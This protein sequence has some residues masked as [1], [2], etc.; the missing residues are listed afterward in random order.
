MSLQEP[1]AQSTN[2][3]TRSLRERH[4]RWWHRRW[5][6][7][8]PTNEVVGMTPLPGAQPSRLERLRL[9]ANRP[10]VHVRTEALIQGGITVQSGAMTLAD[11]VAPESVDRSARDWIRVGDSFLQT[12]QIVSFPPTLALGWLHDPALGLDLPGITVHQCIMPVPDGMAR[13]ILNRSESAAMTTIA[14]DEV[15][16]SSADVEAEQGGR[17]AGDLRRDLAAGRD[18]M[19]QLAITITVSAPS[20][21][22]LRERVDVLR[23]AGAQFGIGL[24]PLRG[25]QWEGYACSLPLAQIPDLA[26]ADVSGKAAAMGLP[27]SSTGIEARGGRP[28]IWGRHPATDAPIIVDRWQQKNPHAVVVAESGS[29]KT[30]AL[31]GQI[32]QDVLLGEDAVL[33]LDPK[34]QEY[35][36]VVQGLGGVYVSMSGRSG[37]HINPL[38]LPRLTPERQRNVATLEED[39]LGQ[40]ITF[41][42]ALLVQEFRAMGTAVTGFGSSTI[43]HAIKQA[44]RERGITSDPATFTEAMPILS[45]VERCFA[46]LVQ[47]EDRDPELLAILRA[48]PH[49]TTGTLGDLFNHP[50]NI[51]VDTPLL[52]LDL[53]ALLQSKDE[54]LERIVPVV[55][56]DFFVTIAINRPTGRRSH[57]ILDEAHALLQSD[58]GS[59]TLQVVYRI[60]R[61]LGFMATV[62]TQSLNDL[63]DTAYARVLLE[64][65]ETKLV[66]GLNKDSDAVRRAADVLHLNE[67]EEAWLAH[68][69]YVPGEGSTALLLIG[70]Q[71]SPLKIPPWPQTLHRMIVHGATT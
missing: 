25:L 37:F 61:S 55:V 44:Y 16:G 58:A 4:A 43:E 70:G 7:D 51:P 9:A 2:G 10:I 19:M 42:K 50:S 12:L 20:L 45:D 59:K 33:I 27:I 35:R 57:V 14:G 34:N 63:L 11:V 53:W 52:G 39:L 3:R 71:R 65:S 21:E 15:S 48:F 36:N 6:R 67:Q 64:N 32:A 28:I 56:M 40:R 49:F 8:R 24:S 1:G 60:G 30:Y 69:G 29:G 68:C 41:V 54:V 22:E 62:V 26:L 47:D 23:L 18:R 5:R 66:M 38:E 17:A 46:T 31:S 13:A